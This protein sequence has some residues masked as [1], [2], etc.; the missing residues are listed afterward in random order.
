MTKTIL[1]ALANEDLQLIKQPINHDSENT[2]AL[3]KMGELRTA[4]EAALGD[5]EKELFQ[6][7]KDTSDGVNLD[8]ATDRFITGFRLGVLMMVEVF[9]ESDSLVRH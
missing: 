4:L 5:A 6:D 3:K 9:A 8:Y 2:H 7:L 1:E